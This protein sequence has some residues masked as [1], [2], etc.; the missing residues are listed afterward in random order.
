MP[1]FQSHPFKI[2]IILLVLP[3]KLEEKFYNDTA[4]YWACTGYIYI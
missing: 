4:I 1:A 3:I 2:E